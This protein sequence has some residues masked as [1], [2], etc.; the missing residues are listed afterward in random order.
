VG[1]PRF[2]PWQLN[3]N[4]P[5]FGGVRSQTLCGHFQFHGG[6]DPADA[7]VRAVIVINPQPLSGLI[8][9]L[10]NA[11]DDVLIQPF[12]PNHAVVALNTDVLPGLP[13]LD[14][15]DGNPMFLSPFIQLFT[16]VFWPVIHLNSAALTAPFD[17]PIKGPD[18]TP[19]RHGKIAPYVQPFTGDVV[20]NIQQPKCTTVPQPVDHE[21][22]GPGHIGCI[23]KWSCKTGQ[24]AEMYPTM[25]TGR[26]NDEETQIFRKVQVIGS[27]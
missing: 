11:F 9:C 19:S 7:D 8:L 27:A 6:C 25:T 4:F 13:R 5:I 2:Q 24:P 18:H 14:V 23:M 21:I 3:G 10:L 20:Q 26:A 12:V 22:H 16:D 1:P 17:D 15:S